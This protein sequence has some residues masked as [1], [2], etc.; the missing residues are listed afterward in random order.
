V[1]RKYVLTGLLLSEQA[2][3]QDAQAS[4]EHYVADGVIHLA[5]DVQMEKFRKRTLEITK[6]RGRKFVEG[7]H[8]YRINQQGI[9]LLPAIY[10]TEEEAVTGENQFSTGVPT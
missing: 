2:S 9:R 8:I 6:M 4:Y 5:L 7:E 1:L 3:R 10:T